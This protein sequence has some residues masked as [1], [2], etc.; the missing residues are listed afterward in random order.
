MTFPEQT[1]TIPITLTQSAAN[2]VREII[3]QKNLQGYSLRLFISGGGC[4][5]YQYSLAM[6]N[7]NRSDDTV[8]ETNGIKLIVDEVSIKYLQG[9]IVDYVD[10]TTG[11][12]FKIINPNTISTC[13]C[14]QENRSSGCTG[15]G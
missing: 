1:I 7:R 6:D 3:N 8:I 5:G 4:S 10:D 14:S 12:G 11:N 9:A 2:A 15:C 13:S